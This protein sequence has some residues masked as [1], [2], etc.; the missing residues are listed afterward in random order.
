MRTKDQGQVIILAAVLLI[1][2]LILLAVLV[3]GARLYI[4]RQAIDRALDGAGKAGLIVVGDRMVTQIVAAQTSLATTTLSSSSS[5]IPPSTTPAPDEYYS[6]LTEEAQ[7]TL[8]APPLQTVVA[9]TVLAS[10]EENGF[11][12]D[13]P[14]VIDIRIS[15]P[16]GYSSND[17]TLAIGLE[18]DYRVVIFFGN[19]LNLTEGVI[20]GRSEQSIPQH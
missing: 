19:V 9:D 15:Y 7:Q 18:L 5:T 13:N 4:E 17:P 14:D 2:L 11:G 8:A 12:P 3:D 20:T 6:W 10:L 1:V 16:D